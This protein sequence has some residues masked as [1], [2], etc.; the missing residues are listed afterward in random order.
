MR[1]L[2][3]LMLLAAVVTVRAEPLGRLFFTP[4][5]RSKLESKQGRESTPSAP[6]A[7]AEAPHTTVTL[8]GVVQRESGERV[9]W[10]NGVPQTQKAP[11]GTGSANPHQAPVAVP[12]STR[13]LEMKVGQ[14]LDVES[15]QVRDG[16]ARAQAPPQGTGGSTPPR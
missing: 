10:V 12:G 13:P 5:E 6:A 11:A 9:I 3:I 7:P 1:V 16:P 8:Q 15:G 14:T 2:A 4:E